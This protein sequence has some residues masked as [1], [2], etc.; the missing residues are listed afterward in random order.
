MRAILILLLLMATACRLRAE[1]GAL[2]GGV[3][4]NGKFEV[5]MFVA[6]DKHADPRMGYVV[7]SRSPARTLLRIP[8]SYDDPSNHFDLA[9]TSDAKVAWSPDSRFVAID[10]AVHRFIGELLLV[11]VSA[12]HASL[13]VVPREAILRR[14]NERWDRES[15]HEPQWTSPRDLS[16]YLHGLLPPPTPEQLPAHKEFDVQLHIEPDDTISVRDVRE[17]ERNGA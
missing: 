11:R 17:I 4:P 14:S 5:L 10:E 13:L 7:M 15:I 9:H 1:R 3:S 16:V 8:S 2:E 12:H 6:S